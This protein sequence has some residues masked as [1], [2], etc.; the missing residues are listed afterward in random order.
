MQCNLLHTEIKFILIYN[1]D[2][3]A[4][5]LQ[6]YI[7][8]NVMKS[9]QYKLRYKLC[10]INCTFESDTGA[11]L[12]LLLVAVSL[13]LSWSC[14]SLGRPVIR[15]LVTAQLQLSVMRIKAH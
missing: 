3:I 6:I 7:A 10:F 13:V 1:F 5:Q 12:C 8:F 4:V 14:I 9:M 11:E 2:A 15:C